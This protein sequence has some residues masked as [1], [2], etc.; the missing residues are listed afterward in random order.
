MAIIT[1][2]G[3]KLRGR[4]VGAITIF[5]AA[6]EAFKTNKKVL[7]MSLRDYKNGHNIEDYALPSEAG[8]TDESG[9][10]NLE[11]YSFSDNGLDAVIRR[12]DTDSLNEEQLDM[13]IT[14][15]LLRAKLD[16][17]RSTKEALFEKNL[18]TRWETIKKILELANRVYDYVFV[19]I[20]ASNDEFVKK[21]NEISDKNIIV[22]RQG[23]KEFVSK[24][25]EPYADKTR[26]LVTDFE[27]ESVW[28]ERRLKSLYNVK[29]SMYIMPHNVRF[30][31]AK[32]D[33]ELIKFAMKN[34][35][36]NKGDYN[37]PLFAEAEK[38]LD[39]IDNKEERTAFSF[40][41]EIELVRKKKRR[42]E[43]RVYNAPRTEQVTEKT[44]L[45]GLG[46]STYTK[47]VF[48]E[49]PMP[50]ENP[51]T[52]TDSHDDMVTNERTSEGETT[53]AE[54]T[55]DVLNDDWFN[56]FDADDSL[57]ETSSYD[58]S[59]TDGEQ[60]NEFADDILNLNL[61]D[62]EEPEKPEIINND[63]TYAESYDD[64]EVN[65]KTEDTSFVPSTF[66]P[67]RMVSAHHEEVVCGSNASTIKADTAFTTI[68]TD[69]RPTMTTEATNVV[70]YIKK[71]VRAA[72]PA[73]PVIEAV[74]ALDLSDIENR[75][76]MIEDLKVECGESHKTLK[77]ESEEYL[78][79]VSNG[80]MDAMPKMQEVLAKI[81]DITAKVA[82]LDKEKT[83]LEIDRAG[84]VNEYNQKLAAQEQ[85]MLDYNNEVKRIDAEYEEAMNRYNA[86]VEEF[87]N[88]LNSIKKPEYP[89]AP[90]FDTL[91]EVD[92][93]DLDTRLSLIENEKHSILVKKASLDEESKALLAQ[94][95]GG[96]MDAMAKMQNVLSEVKSITLK[97]DSMEND[98]K[99]INAE[100]EDRIQRYNTELLRRTEI[101]REYRNKIACMKA[102]Y[103][104]KRNE[105]IAK[106]A[107]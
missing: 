60:K 58:A 23:N 98:I 1:F 74:P 5:T 61:D 46:T 29:S 13:C 30:R 39:F 26:Y 16:I 54:N 33:G 3:S 83:Y 37:Y 44:G 10:L 41:E 62:V 12:A 14:P 97:I 95:T 73:K 55:D 94:V 71:P 6:M 90:V 87:N 101:E 2:Q 68:G 72:Y 80:N 67:E 102:E 31:D 75:I 105:L 57:D 20:P 21:I 103:E 24:E 17:L 22:V 64:A 18:H 49:A 9:M 77:A 38:L 47:A 28:S 92:N 59:E 32:E 91:E 7:V 35:E 78:A 36:L 89:E 99:A 93:T 45:F 56:E 66:V 25:N 69:T 70:P 50:V 4:N 27:D 48:D 106:Y 88:K 96:D 11:G 86:V 84:R 43:L 15:T 100:K 53:A 19:Y 85:I 8:L 82:E 104:R 65:N 63:V 51:E 42:P 52:T 81:Q 40:D 79:E 76:N 34:N 107:S